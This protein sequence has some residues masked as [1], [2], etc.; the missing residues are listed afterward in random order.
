VSSWD[1]TFIRLRAQYVRN[2]AGRVA[3]IAEALDRLAATSDD[4]V[5]L[6]SLYREFHGFAGSGRIYGFADVSTSARTAEQEVAKQ[7]MNDDAPTPDDL[8]RWQ[9]VLAAIRTEFTKAAEDA[10]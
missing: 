7:I 6:A 9:A 1:T 2:A 5:A 8:D 10:E 3:R 4:A